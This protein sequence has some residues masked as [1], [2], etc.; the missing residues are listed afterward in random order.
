MTRRRDDVMS[1]LWK[2]HNSVGVDELVKLAELWA[3]FNPN[4]LSLYVRKC[5]KDQI[6]IGFT[7]SLG[8]FDSHQDFFDRV[9]DT[10]K[11]EYGNNFVGWDLSQFTYVIK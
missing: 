4:F 2:F 11:R 9:T 1:G 10:L 5:S 6:G 7:H 8:T 3:I